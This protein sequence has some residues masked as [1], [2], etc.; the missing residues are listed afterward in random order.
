MALPSFLKRFVNR[1][2]PDGMFVTKKAAHRNKYAPLI[3]RDPV[4]FLRS[5]TSGF[6][7]AVEA[8]LEELPN[9]DDL[10]D[11][12]RVSVGITSSESEPGSKRI[13]S[14]LVDST[15]EEDENILLSKPANAEQ[16][17]NCQTVRNI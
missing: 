8:I 16:F 2:S 1:L 5:R 15:D 4:I 12:R 7:N 10:P 17:R 9:S 11:S 14:D 6:S 13:T 3:T